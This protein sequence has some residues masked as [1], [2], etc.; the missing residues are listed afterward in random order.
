MPGT[1]RELPA[2]PVVVALAMAA[3]A[4]MVLVLRRRSAVNVPRLIVSAA[5]CSYGAGMLANSALPIYL[6]QPADDV[7][8]WV[9]LNLVPLKN[10]ELFDMVENAVVFVPL[11]LLLALIVRRSSL[12]RVL[13]LGFLTSLTMEA[14][15]FVDA[16]TVH[17]GHVADVN[18]LCANTVGAVVGYGIFRAALLVPTVGRWA[19]TAAWPTGSPFRQAR[20][21]TGR[22]IGAP[23]RDRRD[24]NS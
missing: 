16:I 3:F 6:G 1:Y 9:N 18:D 7:P 24:Q 17:G 2:L 20:A 15:Q 13:L 21:A 22:A 5:L 8:W 23:G 10:T 12:R 4:T 14:L 19:G 11:G